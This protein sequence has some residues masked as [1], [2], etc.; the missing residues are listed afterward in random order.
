M[1]TIGRYQVLGL[2]GRGGWAKVFK[3]CLPGLGKVVALKL[4]APRPPLL[5]L[6]DQLELRDRFLVEAR[7]MAGLEHPHLVAVH[8]LDEHQD[9]PFYTMDYH[10]RNLGQVLAESLDPERPCRRLPL[11]R[12]LDYLRQTLLGLER[13]HAAG[14]VHRDLQPF[15]LLLDAADQVR[16]GDF[17]LAMVGGAQ[18]RGRRFPVNLRIGTPF[19]A[20]P[21]QDSDPGRADPRADLYGVGMIL[22]R[23]LGGGLD[24]VQAGRVAEL[25]PGLGTIWIEFLETALQPD[26]R[27]RFEDA[28]A[29]L[30]GLEELERD[31]RA[32]ADAVCRLEPR[33]D[34]EAMGEGTVRL[35]SHP[36]RVAPSQAAEVFHLDRLGR[37]RSHGPGRFLAGE[38]GCLRDPAHGL[39]WQAG[40]SR[41]ALTWPEARAWLEELNA[42]EWAGVN[43]WRVPTLAELLTLVEPGEETRRWCGWT[44]FD[45]R[46]RRLW[47][48]DSR[49]ALANWGL[50]LE[51]GC[52]DWWDHGCRLHLRAVR[53]G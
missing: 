16:L 27:R 50:D 28:T 15:N 1:K 30:A 18:S 29:M 35:R 38:P 44:L 52:A 42:K 14:L 9:R 36:L 11:A 3:V 33:P 5:A 19:Y 8:D 49:S 40:G 20:A 23:M 46:Q 41:H 10:C 17:G 48:A 4:L 22:L 12:A 34:S 13:L 31:W 26:P 45:P 25:H 43:G 32:R 2:L 7:T 53:D 6:F 39:I 47:S 24:S 37:P 21:E 51:M